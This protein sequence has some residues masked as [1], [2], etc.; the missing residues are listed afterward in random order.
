MASNRAGSQPKK[1]RVG[2]GRRKAVEPAQL[3]AGP[4]R[5]NAPTPAAG[6]EPDAGE[7]ETP[8][9]GAALPDAR[10]QPDPDTQPPDEREVEVVGEPGAR[11]RI[12]TELIKGEQL[13]RQH[14]GRLVTE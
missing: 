3:D 4:R 14:V 6:A 5:A 10:Q 8:S 2:L 11:A 7:G 9:D 1:R 13:T 12:R